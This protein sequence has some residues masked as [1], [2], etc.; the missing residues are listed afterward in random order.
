MLGVAYENINDGLEGYVTLTGDVKGLDTDAYTIGDVLYIDPDVPGGL[1]TT[2]PE[3]P[4]VIMSIA[5]VTKV[6]SSAGHI[7]VRMWSQQALLEELHDVKVDTPVV[8]QTLVYNNVSGLW[9]NELIAGAVYQAD[10]P[11]GPSVGQV[12]VDSDATAG[13]LNQNDYVLKTEAE[14]YTPHSFL[15]MGG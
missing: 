3:T 6:N 10:A 9:E 15:L 4:D 12:W 7:F 1:T 5:I 13:V 2:K 11:T 14:A 8:G